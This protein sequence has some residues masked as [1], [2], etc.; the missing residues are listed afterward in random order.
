M[1]ISEALHAA[2]D[3]IEQNPGGYR[4]MNAMVPTCGESGCM[5]GKLGKLAGARPGVTVNEVAQ[6]LLGTF[7]EKFYERVDKSFAPLTTPMAIGNQIISNFSFNVH[8][9][10][11]AAAGMRKLAG[12]YKLIPDD[13]RAIFADNRGLHVEQEF[14]QH[15]H[16]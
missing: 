15:E 1:N 6:R 10:A 8:D 3:D 14:H 9:P 7:P 16:V 12:K 2:A 5:L 13:I 11:M 4:F